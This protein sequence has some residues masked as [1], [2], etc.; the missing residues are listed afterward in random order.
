V[1]LSG[2]DLA[3]SL[4][5]LI[6]TQGE[7]FGSTSIFAQNRVFGLAADNG[8]KVTLDGQG[9]DEIMAGYVPFL[10]ARLATLFKNGNWLRGAHLLTASGAVAGGQAGVALRATRFLLPEFLQGPARRLVGEGLMPPWMNADWFARQGVVAQAPQKPIEGDVLRHELLESLTDRVLPALLRYQDR[11]SMAH[12]VESRVP[13]L[14]PKL[15]DFLYSLPE[16]F[17]ISDEGETKS[18]FRA[19]M[20]GLV[21]DAILDRRDKVGFATPQQSWLGEDQAWLNTVLTSDRLRAISAFDAQGMSREM[22][23]VRQGQKPL[24]G[25]VWR[26]INLTRWAETFDVDFAA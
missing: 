9:A 3:A 20:R 25:D 10:A 12:S 6:A 19:A 21:P 26:W 1:A 8:I 24:A 17:L 4:D 14:T 13:F 5:G 16:D 2:G 15:V 7:P 18:V 22:D 11:N 23:A